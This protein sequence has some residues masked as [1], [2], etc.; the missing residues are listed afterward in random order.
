MAVAQGL[1]AVGV[2]PGLPVGVGQVQVGCGKL[3]V[4]QHGPLKGCDRLVHPALAQAQVAQV[5]I[6]RRPVRILGQ[7]VHVFL[8]CLRP[9]AAPF[10]RDLLVRDVSQH[11]GGLHAH[12]ANGVCQQWRGGG[13]ARRRVEGL[14]RAGRRC[15]KQGVG[16][17]QQLAQRWQRLRLKMGL[18]QCQRG[19]SHDRRQGGIFRQRHERGQGGHALGCAGVQGAACLWPCC[20]S[21]C[22]TTRPWPLR[23]IAACGRRGSGCRRRA[24]PACR[25]GRGVARG[26][27]GR[28]GH[29]PPCSCAPACGIRRTGRPCCRLCA[30]GAWARRKRP[31]CGSA[32]TACCRRS[33][34]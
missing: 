33:A 21:R 30:H 5:D 11:P 34:A 3:G 15:A 29:R 14:E 22:R 32:R 16:V 28:A 18:C 4:E 2:A 10:H 12:A 25:S 9:R 23:P 17:G 6:G 20:A 13:H 27:R 24:C 26:W 8:E 7:R 1:F 19:R 31:R